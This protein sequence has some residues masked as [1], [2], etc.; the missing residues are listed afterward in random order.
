V[1]I[2]D[3]SP[4]FF[5][6]PEHRLKT[7]AERSFYRDDDHLTRFGAEHYLRPVFE[8]IFEDI[9]ATKPATRQR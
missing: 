4:A 8:G 3:P 2:L 1:T 9:Q 6:N 7:F 5:D